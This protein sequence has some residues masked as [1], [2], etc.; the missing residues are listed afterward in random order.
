MEGYADTVT[1]RTARASGANGGQC[2]EIGTATDSAVVLIRDSKDRERGYL[3][4]TRETFRRFI[5]DIT[6]ALPAGHGRPRRA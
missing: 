4:V 2:V 6:R 3:T 1:W 5:D